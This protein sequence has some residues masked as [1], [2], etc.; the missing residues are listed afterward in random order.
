MLLEWSAF[1]KVLVFYVLTLFIVSTGI[2][3]IMHEYA[4]AAVCKDFLVTPL[5]ARVL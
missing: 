3:W 2:L 4:A 5:E 1:Q